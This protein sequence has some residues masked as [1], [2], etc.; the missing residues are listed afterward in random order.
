MGPELV[1]VDTIGVLMD[2]IRLR[3]D[4]W[5]GD[6]DG[7]LQ[8]EEFQETQ[9]ADV[10]MTVET[11][12]WTAIAAPKNECRPARLA[13]IDGVRRAD[14]RVIGETARKPIVYGMF[15]SVAVGAVEVNGSKAAIERVIVRRYLVLGSN[16][17][18]DPEAFQIGSTMVM[19]DPYSTAESGP[20]GPMLA[21]QNLM[22]AEEASLA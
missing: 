13:F 2:Q 8:I 7:A 15:G 9:V 4:P 6:Y 1:I 12:A 22:R 10:D 20:T 17:S 18:P 5:P 14:A 3:L 16:Q 19:F 11:P 21:L